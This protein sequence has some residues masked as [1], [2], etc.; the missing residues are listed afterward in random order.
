MRCFTACAALKLPVHPKGT[1]VNMEGPGVFHAC[2]V[3]PLPQLGDGYHRH[4]ESGGGQACREAEI[5]YATLAAI[6]DYDC[7]HPSHA[8]VSI[9]MIIAKT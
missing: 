2:G 7:W 8:T 9:D 1:Y 5:C 6:T 4:D 3:E